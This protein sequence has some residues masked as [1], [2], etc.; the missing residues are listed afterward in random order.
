LKES[1]TSS[2]PGFPANELDREMMTEFE[3]SLQALKFA[4]DARDPAMTMTAV[5][6]VETWLGLVWPHVTEAVRRETLMLIDHINSDSDDAAELSRLTGYLLN[7]LR[8]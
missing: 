1:L 2:T 5:V 4:L 7:L 8:I 6:M 3:S